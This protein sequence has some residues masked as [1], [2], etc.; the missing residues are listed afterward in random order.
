MCTEFYFNCRFWRIYQIYV[1]DAHEIEH[2]LYC[3]YG[4]S[5]KE[6]KMDFLNFPFHPMLEIICLSDVAC[7]LF[8][9]FCTIDY[10]SVMPC[11]SVIE[12]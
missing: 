7:V 12:Y 8:F 3:P 2:L 4:E 1:T 9:I 11:F 10:L 6:G 5:W